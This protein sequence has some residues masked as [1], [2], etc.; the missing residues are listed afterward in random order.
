[1]RTRHYDN[2]GSLRRNMEQTLRSMGL[3]KYAPELDGADLSALY[4]SMVLAERRYACHPG[5]VFFVK[6][7]PDINIQPGFFMNAQA[8]RLDPASCR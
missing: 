6:T 5:Q 4:G 1:M 3:Q 2:G 8:V 7:R